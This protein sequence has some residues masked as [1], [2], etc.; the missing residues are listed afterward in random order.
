MESTLDCASILGSLGFLYFK[1]KKYL[2]LSNFLWECLRLYHNNGEFKEVWIDFW[3]ILNNI[4][5]RSL[6]GEILRR[7][8]FWFFNFGSTPRKTTKGKV[9]LFFSLGRIELTVNAHPPA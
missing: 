3:S 4:V 5:F 8:N 2:E 6:Y 1:L 9:P 7:V